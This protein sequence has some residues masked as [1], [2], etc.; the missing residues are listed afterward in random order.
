MV[1]SKSSS[2]SD[3]ASSI[4]PLVR[5]LKHTHPS[6]LCSTTPQLHVFD[7]KTS[8]GRLDSYHHP[9]MPPCGVLIESF[10]GHNHA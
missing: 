1:S 3:E 8:L 6:V 4:K 2:I 9:Q 7:A 10:G 5:G